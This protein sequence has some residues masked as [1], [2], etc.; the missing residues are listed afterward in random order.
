MTGAE[1]AMTLEARSI[2]S[3]RMG[4][5]QWILFLT[6]EIADPLPGWGMGLLGQDAAQLKNLI[7]Q[8]SRFLELQVP[9]SLLHLDFQLGDEALELTGWHLGGADR[10]LTTRHS[11]GFST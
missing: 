4:V 2:Q 1:G 7:P 3:Q 11:L 6:G 10:A 9:G 5:S 8:G